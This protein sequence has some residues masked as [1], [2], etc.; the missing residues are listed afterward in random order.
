MIMS[1]NRNM[2]LV[3]TMKNFEKYICGWLGVVYS[4]YILRTRHV[5]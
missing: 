2:Y 1:S 4:C 3:L 5:N